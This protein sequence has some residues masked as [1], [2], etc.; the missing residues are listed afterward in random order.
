MSQAEGE[1]RPMPTA[2]GLAFWGAATLVAI[3]LAPLLWRCPQGHLDSS[4]GAVLWHARE[5]GL[6]FGTDVVFTYGPLGHVTVGCA[7][8]GPWVATFWL[9]TGFVLLAFVPVAIL[10]RRLPWQVAIACAAAILALPWYTTALDT[11]VP[12]GLLA[13]GVL[14]LTD[15]RHSRWTWLGLALLAGLGGLAKF[16]WLVIGLVTVSAVSGDLV[17]RRRPRAAVV[18]ALAALGV[19]LAGWLLAGQALADLPAYLV[20]SYQLAAGYSKAMGVPGSR[21]MLLLHGACAGLCLWSAAAAAREVSLPAGGRLPLRRW[22]FFGWLGVLAFLAWKHGVFRAPAGDIHGGILAAWCLGAGFVMAAV[23]CERPNAVRFGVARACAIACLALV[24]VHRMGFGPLQDHL[25]ASPRR[26][27]DHVRMLVG[28]DPRQPGVAAGCRAKCEELD[29]PTTRALVGEA[30]IDAFGH[31]QDRLIVSGLAYAPRPVF[32]SYSAYTRQLQELNE[33]YYLGQNAPRWALVALE[34]IDGRFPPLEDAACLRAILKNYRLAGR[35]PPF[36][37]TERQAAEPVT[38]ERV[39]EGVAT[40]GERVS[41][42]EHGGGDLWL[43]IDVSPS[44]RGRLE[45]LLVRPPPCGIRLWSAG[46]GDASEAFNAPAALLAAGF[47][48][49]PLLTTTAD[50]ADVLSGQAGRRLAAFA[51]EGKRVA[52]GRYRWRLAA[53]RGGL[54]GRAAAAPAAR[55]YP[56][57]DVQPAASRSGG[58]VMIVEVDGTRMLKVD[59]P[60]AIV[61]DV[62]AGATSVE[63]RFA[64]LAAAYEQGSTDGAEFIVDYEAGGPAPRELSRRLLAPTTQPDDRGIQRFRLELP[65]GDDRRIILRTTTGPADNPAWDWTC[66]SDVRFQPAGGEAPSAR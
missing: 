48:A 20:H 61:I 5:H 26:L 29:L 2:G 39:A 3:T 16:T 66:W 24:I 47:I 32:Q 34:P 45:S 44:L 50:V 33:R 23:P 14:A 31:G 51:V 9:V 6:Q 10:V 46:A 18:P 21:D 7:A 57:F 36:L 1:S 63:G 43:E 52:G 15:E 28:S 58:P 35:E 37:I 60:S 13:W 30:S 62:P 11:L 55:E 19:F 12:L 49:S 64:I 41:V 65:A 40:V 38:L 25:A 4:W 8:D 27:V 59:P 53:I 56:G 17:L 22:L 42:A 54:V